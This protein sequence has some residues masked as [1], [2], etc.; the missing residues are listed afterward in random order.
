MIMITKGGWNSERERA[1]N[2]MSDGEHLLSL[3]WNATTF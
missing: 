1:E 3:G 2:N